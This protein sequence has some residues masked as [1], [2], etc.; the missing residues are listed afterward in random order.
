[1]FHQFTFNECNIMENWK[2]GFPIE[3][4]FPIDGIGWNFPNWKIGAKLER[5]IIGRLSIIKIYLL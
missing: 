1:M 4:K 5:L 2:D 3:W